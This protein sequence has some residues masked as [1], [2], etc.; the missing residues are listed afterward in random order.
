MDAIGAASAVAYYPAMHLGLG[1]VMSATAMNLVM[2]VSFGVFSWLSWFDLGQDGDDGEPEAIQPP[3]PFIDSSEW[4]RSVNFAVVG[5]S[6]AGKSSL[7]NVL[8]GLGPCDAGAAA[9][10][11]D[12]GAAEPRPYPLPTGALS[13]PASPMGSSM[14]AEV[15]AKGGVPPDGGDGGGGGGGGAL[16]K[17][18]P[19][20]VPG[21][22]AFVGQ[23][24]VAAAAAAVGGT[25]AGDWTAT[26]KESARITTL[27]LW[28]M[29]S[30]DG[31]THTPESLCN[32]LGLAYFDAVVIVYSERLTNFEITLLRR[33]DET[34][35]VPTFLVRSQVDVDV[36]NECADHGSSE[37]ETL[38]KLR[39][40]A[41]VQGASSTYLVDATDPG[42]HDLPDLFAGICKI[43]RAR[44]RALAETECPI[45]F[46]D[47][48]SVGQ[49][50][51]LC[52]WCGNVVCGQCAR[53]L[54]SPQGEA[55]CPFCRRCTYLFKQPATAP[56]S[57][58]WS[59]LF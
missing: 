35:R 50:S 32:E 46:E 17:P 24:D 40:E 19:N 39:G 31:G 48:K 47:F 49:E 30:F 34:M 2:I 37:A 21:S 41:V 43:A 38:G 6:G 3:P 26:S 22:P 53:R 13:A 23:D 1:S 36:E 7:V 4:G 8:R 55:T 29:P 12:G 20:E 14:V 27:R 51:R 42:R 25:M 45:C 54:R 15:V 11:I 56:E 16:G 44:A 28:D 10:G 5:P 18:V 59:T 58:M 33:L 57:G 52:H 9:V